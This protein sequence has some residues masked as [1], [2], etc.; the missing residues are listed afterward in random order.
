M[1]H[2]FRQFG[3]STQL[4][5]M[6]LDGVHAERPVFALP[7]EPGLLRPFGNAFSQPDFLYHD[8]AIYL[9]DNEAARPDGAK[10]FFAPRYDEMA[11]MHDLAVIFLPKGKE[12]I[13]FVFSSVSKTL[14][15]GAGV[16]VV[17]PKKSGIRSC[18]PLVEKY[19][20]SVL[21]SRSARHCVVIEAEKTVET[22]LF[23]GKKSYSVAVFGKELH[24][25]TLPGVFSHGQLD[26][27]TGVLLAHLDAGRVSFKKALDFGCG[28]GV[29]GAALKLAHPKKKVDFVDSNVMALEAA[30]QTLEANSFGPDCVWAS[31]VF[32]H[33]S[34]RYDL[35]VSNPPYHAGLMT[36]FSVTERLIQEANRH[37]TRSGRLVIVTNAFGKYAPH[38]RQHF[39]RVRMAGKRGHYRIIEASKEIKDG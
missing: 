1:E 10:L 15:H 16:I 31:D 13:E 37:L 12:L 7:P 23:E 28:A 30:R 6:A 25:V 22:E 33:V 9:R 20:G 26:E 5:G 8:Y 21:S 27:G 35:I 14:E 29:I 18:K 32:S 17:G 3:R 38:L 36:D 19:F 24:V 2:V 39:G 4:A 34:R 11:G